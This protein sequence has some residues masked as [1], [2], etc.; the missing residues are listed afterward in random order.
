MAE[1][2]LSHASFAACSLAFSILG[3]ALLVPDIISFIF[4]KKALDLGTNFVCEDSNS[5]VSLSIRRTCP[6]MGDRA[7]I[8]LSVT[9]TNLVTDTLSPA[10][11]KFS[12]PGSPPGVPPPKS[13][14]YVTIAVSVLEDIPQFVLRY[15]ASAG[16]GWN[17][18]PAGTRDVPAAC[19]PTLSCKAM[20]WSCKPSSSVLLCHR[21]ALVL[22]ATTTLA[23]D[24]TGSSAATHARHCAA[25]TP[26]LHTAT[27]CLYLRVSDVFNENVC[28]RYKKGVD[29]LASRVPIIVC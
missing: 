26:Q 21:D 29:G 17:L 14:H 28:D 1:Q 12:S 3:T 27:S 22:N 2:G 5:I 25:R 20:F 6:V 13:A 9:V 18:R 15:A 24:A 11:I 16:L 4:R 23:H 19:A 8:E 10:C 7:E